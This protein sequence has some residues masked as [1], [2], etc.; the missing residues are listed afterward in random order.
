MQF[1]HFVIRPLKEQDL[2]SYF[3]L[4]QK[5]RERLEDFFAGTV[6]KTQTLEDTKQFISSMVSR[7]NE[8]SYFAYVIVDTHHNDLI[9]FLDLKNI[10]WNIPKSE[11]GCYIDEDYANKG[12]TTKASRLFCDYCFDEFKFKK[13]F[14]RT[15]KSNTSAIRLAESCDFQKEGIIRCDYKTS[16]GKLVDLIY[17]GR[18]NSRLIR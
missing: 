17:F 15:H 2:D 7:A 10:D 18:L 3:K 14:I 6:S 13:L 1:D 9:G 12:I 11:V 8:R 16:S 5:N 4:V